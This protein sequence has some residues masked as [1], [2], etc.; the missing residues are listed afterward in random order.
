[1]LFSLKR[2]WFLILFMGFLASCNS[3]N[4]SSSEKVVLKPSDITFATERADDWTQTFKRDSGW[5]GGDGIFVIP[6]SGNDTEQQKD[7]LLFVFSDTMIGQIKNDSLLPG[8]KMVNNS[9]AILDTKENPKDIKFKLDQNDKGYAAFFKPKTDSEEYYWL[10]DGFVNKSN[11]KLYLFAYRIRNTN[12]DDLLPFEETGNDLLVID[13]KDDFPLKATKQIKLSFFNELSAE[14]KI[15]FGVGVY[16][17]YGSKDPN[18]YIYGVRGKSKDLVV[19]RVKP[20]HIENLEAWE[21]LGENGWQTS[22]EG[23]QALST[24]VSNELS[25]SKITDNIFG[26]VYQE[27]GIYPK[28]YLKMASTPYGPFGEK[29][30]LWDT[31]KDIQDPDL[32]TYNAKAHPALSKPGELL[33]SYNVNSFKFFDIIEAKPHLYRPRFFKIKFN[34]PVVNK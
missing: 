14:N 26:L 33:V 31:T 1:M 25:V 9:L 16:E 15:S 4:K 13:N 22:W 24:S 30:L 2:K 21:F 8:Y 5:F 19:A 7:S 20:P 27:G 23:L 3:K 17:D 28:I 32:F 12:T 10:G 29:Q 11:K 18:I 6:Y 34:I